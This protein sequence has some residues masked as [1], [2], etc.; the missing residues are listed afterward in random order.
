MHMVGLWRWSSIIQFCQ[1][2]TKIIIMTCLETACTNWMYEG[3]YKTLSCKMFHN[4][5]SLKFKSKVVLRYVGLGNL[6]P[7]TQLLNYKSMM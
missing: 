5:N 4:F 3:E 2:S 7:C 6:S 1:F